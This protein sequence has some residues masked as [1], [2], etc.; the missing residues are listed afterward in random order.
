MYVLPVM[1]KNF[2][3]SLIAASMALFQL[4][5]VFEGFDIG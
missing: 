3:Q 1:S 5:P 2:S 4:D